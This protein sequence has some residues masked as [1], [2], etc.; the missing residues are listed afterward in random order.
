M[1]LE[2]IEGAG[3]ENSVNESY[4]EEIYAEKIFLLNFLIHPN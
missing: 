2:E 4:S 1:R 3:L